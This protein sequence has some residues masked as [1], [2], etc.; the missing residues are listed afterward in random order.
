MNTIRHAFLFVSLFALIA[1]AT[2]QEA[3]K[4][5][6]RFSNTGLKVSIGTTSLSMIDER[7]I[8]EGE[9]GVLSLGYGFSD[10]FSLWLSVLG[11][12]HPQ[13]N[14]EEKNTEFGGIELNIQH[15]FQ[16]NSRLQP[17][18]KVGVGLYGLGEKDS[19]IQL[20]GGG[21]NIGI[22]VDY[23]FSRHFGIGAET[24]YKKLDYVQQII[25]S[26]NGE[27]V[28][29]LSPNLN[30]DAVAFSLSLTIQ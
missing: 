3:T 30:G 7:K 21:V 1:S 27:I 2:A 5:T 16:S 19:G 8:Q 26:A 12:Q 6:P 10:R 11:S 28:R 20:V 29:D 15:K 13:L 23:F 9:G 18:G 4:Q 22:G 17:Y 25:S 14:N 24:T